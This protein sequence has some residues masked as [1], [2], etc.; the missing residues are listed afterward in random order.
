ME[1][2]QSRR[3]KQEKPRQLNNTS[4]DEM[5]DPPSTIRQSSLHNSRLDLNTINFSSKTMLP[6]IVNDYIDVSKNNDKIS[7]NYEQCFTSDFHIS[8]HLQNNISAKNKLRFDSHPTINS[9]T[10]KCFNQ[11]NN[12]TTFEEKIGTLTAEYRE[13]TRVTSTPSQHY[14][15][16]GIESVS[17]PVNCIPYLK[18]DENAITSKFY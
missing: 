7:S 18:R 14:F 2:Q 11:T 10:P 17:H 15:S 3:R 16:S 12:K 9:S 6:N 1:L 13:R 4:E 8:S 5:T